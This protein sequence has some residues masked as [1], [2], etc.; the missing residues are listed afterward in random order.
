MAAGLRVKREQFE[1]FREK[2]HSY[3]ALRIQP[4]QLVSEIQIDAEVPLHVLTPGFIRAL[5]VLEP[6]GQTNPAPL[7]LATDVTVVGEPKCVGGGD[8]HLRFRVSQGGMTMWAIA[9][10]QAERAQDLTSRHGK[11]CLVFRPILNSYGGSVTVQLQVKDLLPGSRLTDE[12]RVSC[13]TF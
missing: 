8:R 4:D 11:C 12:T 2:I 6:C 5:E 10:D 1:V 13:Q 9:F 3:A 7:L